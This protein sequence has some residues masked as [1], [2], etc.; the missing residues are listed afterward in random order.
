MSEETA[1]RGVVIKF[2][3]LS[4]Y[5]TKEL[6]VDVETEP[7]HSLLQRL[8][9]S[10]NCYVVLQGKKLNISDTLSQSGYKVQEGAEP[11]PVYV[12][13]FI[14]KEIWTI[15]IKPKNAGF[16][17]P[18]C[19]VEIESDATVE[20]LMI[21]IAEKAD[22]CPIES[23]I[24]LVRDRQARGV[25]NLRST[26]NSV[27]ENN[28]TLYLWYILLNLKRIGLEDFVLKKTPSSQYAYVNSRVFITLKDYQQVVDSDRN[29]KM[30]PYGQINMEESTFSID[31]FE[32]N[33]KSS[34]DENDPNKTIL[35]PIPG[36]TICNPDTRIA[37]WVPV[38][39]DNN[40]TKF[41][42]NTNYVVTCF[43]RNLVMEES[44]FSD[45][46][47]PTGMHEVS[48]TFRTQEMENDENEDPKDTVICKK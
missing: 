46:R 8:D 36:K 45:S 35:I 2:T 24:G 27:T 9:F 10:E 7:I 1:K 11:L 20:D 48:W 15:N 44:S 28:G 26:I 37:E 33:Y 29:R 5:T 43:G 21:K 32:V 14:N 23:Q 42:Y 41:K 39:D 4:P 16:F 34:S 12:I 25:L 17:E 3:L 31:L 13:P 19:T 47:T 18:E 38:D 6:E 30:T 40:I 22:L